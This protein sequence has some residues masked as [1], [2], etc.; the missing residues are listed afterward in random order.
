MNFLR[1]LLSDISI[2]ITI[3]TFFASL[4]SKKSKKKLLI[5]SV[6]C[7][8][9][10]VLLSLVTRLNDKVD[11]DINFESTNPPIVSTTSIPTTNPIEVSSP[12]PTPY[13]KRLLSL[14]PFVISSGNTEI[15]TSC[16][17]KL[18]NT[19]ELCAVLGKRTV[20]PIEPSKYRYN[21]EPLEYNLNN[22]YS[23]LTGTIAFYD[24]TTESSGKI[25]IFI[26]D[27]LIYTSPDIDMR[28]DPI[29]FDIELNYGKFLKIL[30]PTD[31]TAFYESSY[32][33]TNLVLYQ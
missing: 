29:D 15:K 25:T 33:V 3:V 8:V 5:I 18:G 22:S 24:G 31:S 16:E 30:C 17:D 12:I 14:E 1:T 9:I 4:M 19:F 32:I 27:E 23:R 13:I 21:A 2:A 6:V 7:L 20:D 10:Y 28:T 26:D 11:D